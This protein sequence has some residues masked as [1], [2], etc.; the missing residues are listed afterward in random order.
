MLVC[1]EKGDN[2]AMNSGIFTFS[3]QNTEA[4][5][6]P[7]VKLQFLF[8]YTIIFACP[9]LFPAG[10]DDYAIDIFSFG[11]CALEVREPDLRESHL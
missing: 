2:T 8:V 5:A 3:P 10:E 7:E 6:H 4:S 9:L 11:I 1:M